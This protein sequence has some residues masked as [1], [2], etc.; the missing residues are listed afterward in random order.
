[1]K[2]LLT[3]ERKQYI[4]MISGHLGDER[5][6]ESGG[7]YVTKRIGRMIGNGKWEEGWTGK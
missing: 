6:K 1:M 7:E 4:P 3:L 2:T 5:K